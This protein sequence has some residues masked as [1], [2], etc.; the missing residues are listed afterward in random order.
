MTHVLPR[1]L[2]YGVHNLAAPIY[3][4]PISVAKAST[5][6]GVEAAMVNNFRFSLQMHQMGASR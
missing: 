2:D 4:Q 5:T 6:L 3:L 1:L